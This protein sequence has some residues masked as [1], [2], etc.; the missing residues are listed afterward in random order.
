MR[1]SLNKIKKLSK[2]YYCFVIEN[3]LETNSYVAHHIEYGRLPFNY[4]DKITIN[5]E[6]FVERPFYGKIFSD[7][8][9]LNPEYATPYNFKYIDELKN[10]I[11]EYRMV[12]NFYKRVV[13]T[14]LV[15]LI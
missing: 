1:L 11:N 3:D 13:R 14:G 7:Y 5:P 2:N 4:Y 9:I 12:L 6:I 10:Y 15:S 8:E